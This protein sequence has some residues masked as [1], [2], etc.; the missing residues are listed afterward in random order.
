LAGQ[1]ARCGEQRWGREHGCDDQG[2]AALGGGNATRLATEPHVVNGDGPG[3]LLMS[4]M[5]GKGERGCR[6][7]WLLAGLRWGEEK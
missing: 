4:F 5:W 7:G 3:G 1:Q 6:L 2:H